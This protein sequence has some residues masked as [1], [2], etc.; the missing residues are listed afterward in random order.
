MTLIWRDQTPFSKTYDDMYYSPAGGW[1]ESQHVFLQGNQLPQRWQGQNF[2]IAELGFGTGLNFVATWQAWQQTQPQGQLTF[3]SFEKHPL[4]WFELERAL[5]SWPEL[6]PFVAQLK[7]VYD[8]TGGCW[9]W[10][11]VTLKLVVGEALT[12]VT[13]WL[14]QADA[15]YLDGFAPAKNPAM[16]SPALLQQVAK[17]TKPNG[18]LATFTVAKI[19][20]E[21]LTNAGFTLIKQP[22][23]GHKREML[24]GTLG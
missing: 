2:A 13:S 4:D 3:T 20:R 17:H 21:G 16:W 15:W 10:G 5:S 14:D 18:T 23:F 9:V 1:A 11:N 7:N 8:P 19:V 12:S 22:G 6:A 24:T